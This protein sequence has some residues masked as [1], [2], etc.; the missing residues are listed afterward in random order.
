MKEILTFLGTLVVCGFIAYF[1]IGHLSK[2][3]DAER[4]KPCDQYSTYP[5]KDVPARC[6]DFYSKGGKYAL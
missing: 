6:Y 3:I 1:A 4:S 5:I 2:V